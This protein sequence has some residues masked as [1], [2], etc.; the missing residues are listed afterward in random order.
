M[1]AKAIN[2]FHN[3]FGSKIRGL[4]KLPS[5]SNRLIPLTIIPVG[6]VVTMQSEERVL[7]ISY[8]KKKTQQKNWSKWKRGGR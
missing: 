2:N 6:K 8:R 3:R 1:L 4:F 5:S 7:S